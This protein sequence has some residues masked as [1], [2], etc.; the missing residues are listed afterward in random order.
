MYQPSQKILEKYANVIINFALG[1]GSGIK[2]GET[3]RLTAYDIAKPFYVELRRAVL[4]SG[5][6]VLGNYLPADE[7]KMNLEKEFY[8]LADE[9]QLKFFPDKFL[10]GLIDQIDH[11][12]FIDSDTNKF[13]LKDVDPKKIM[14][15]SQVFKP[16]KEWRDEK[17][18]KGKFTW[19]I[20]IYATEAMAKEAGLSLKEYWNQIIKACFLDKHDPV[21]EWKNVYEKIGEYKNKLSE[22]KIEKLRIIGPDVDLK[23]NMGEKRK[24]VGGSGRNMPSFEIFTSPDW[25]CAEGW[26][27]FNQPLYSYGNI[28]EGIELEFKDGKVVKAKAKKNEKVLLEMIKAE[29]ADKIG[30]FSLTDKRFSRITKFMGET[31]YDENMG[32]PNGNFHIALGSSYHDAF[33]GNLSGKT[34]EFWRNLG[35]N[36]SAIHTDIVSTS[37]RTV[38]AILKNGSEKIIYKNGQFCL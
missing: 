28:I 2:K 5:G 14:A 3:V 7:R 32:G 29:N 1:G 31:L 36:D 35:F 10:K 8:D 19:T 38:T 15:T 17:E 22:L 12:V 33:G 21:K 13:A 34:K 25:R 26:A 11:S 16:F 24:W 6:S 23:I 9:N 20:A 18:N 4:K 27:K 37:P 30:E